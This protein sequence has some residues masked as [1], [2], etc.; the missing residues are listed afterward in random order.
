MTPPDEESYNGS[1]EPPDHTHNNGED[2]HEQGHTHDHDHDD[3]EYA[4]HT[5]QDDDDD[6]VA[7][8]LGQGDVAQFSVPEMD[9]PSCAGKVENSVENLDGIESV[10]P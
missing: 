3:H 9:C 10:D 7:P 8:Q 2:P 5:G 6:D 1:G 4:Q